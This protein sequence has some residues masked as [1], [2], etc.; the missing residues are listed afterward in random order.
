MLEAALTSYKNGTIEAA[1]VIEELISVAKKIREEENR[2]DVSGLNEDE[3]LFYDALIANGSA[4]EVMKDDQLRDLARILVQQVRNDAGIDW[5]L[6]YNAQ[7]K[8][9]INVKKIL[10]KYGYPPDQQ[11]IATDLVLEQAKAYGDIWSNQKK[12]DNYGGA[13]LID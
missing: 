9:R 10:R 7:A 12:A 1:Q 3:I 13:S 11:A 8:L 6:R 4:T 2:E 5:Q